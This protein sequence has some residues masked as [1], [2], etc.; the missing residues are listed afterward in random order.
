ME[1][2]LYCPVF[3]YY[4]RNG[5]N[6]GSRGDFVTSVSHGCLYGRFLASQFIDWCAD[7]SG[8]VQWV[9]A[10][11]HDGT[12]AADILSEVQRISP[13]MFDRLEYVI[14][15]PSE[16][17]RAWQ[18]SKLHRFLPKVRWCQAPLELQPE[19]IQG[20]IFSNE[21]L[22]AFPIHRLHWDADRKRWLEWGV[23]AS[24]ERFN[25]QH[26]PEDA[27]DW[28]QALRDAGFDIPPELAAVLPDGFIVELSPEAG[29]WWHEVGRSLKQ[30]RLL[31]IDYGYEAAEFLTPARRTGTLRAYRRHTVGTDLLATPGEQDLTAHVNF[32]Q[33][34]RAGEAA[35]LQTDPLVSQSE[36][37][38]ASSRRVWSEANLPS[39]AEVRQ[40]QSLTHPEHLGRA[41]RVL[42]QSRHA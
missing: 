26:M 34:I 15:E 35:G 22:D 18:A 41:F 20:I 3:G 6:V 10:G 8:P 7:F 2:A 21:L 24:R 39:P 5:G 4:E 11:A 40:F 29:R 1:L 33:L 31:T 42:V 37:L 30:G 32:S 17:R 9:E 14:L 25:W 16:H 19:T 28:N 36:F 23:V 27:K 12:L 38:A 13:G